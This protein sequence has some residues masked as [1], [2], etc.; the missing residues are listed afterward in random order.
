MNDDEGQPRLSGLTPEQMAEARKDL[1]RARA[2]ELAI[3]KALQDMEPRPG[4]GICVTACAIMLG[5]MLAI[6]D[7]QTLAPPSMRKAR[8][9]A[10]LNTITASY[11]AQADL[12]G[13]AGAGAGTNGKGKA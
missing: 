13:R 2:V 12:I 4:T 3:A 6:A 11:D 7:S 9:T 5:R 10:T 1:E 8:M